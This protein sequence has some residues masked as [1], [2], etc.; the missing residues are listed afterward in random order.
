M[1]GE[2]RGI[3]ATTRGAVPL[4]DTQLDRFDVVVLGGLDRLT[5]ND[6]AGVERYMRERG[7]GVVLLPDQR[8][9]AGPL[10]PLLPEFTERLLE[11]PASLVSARR[12]RGAACVRAPR[13]P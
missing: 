1:N 9:D 4:G 5:A 2:S 7:G 10:R 12:R 13:G 8:V 11:R 6:V 3:T